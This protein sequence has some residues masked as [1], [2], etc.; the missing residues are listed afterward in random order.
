MAFIPFYDYTAN[1]FSFK[2]YIIN[3]IYWLYDIWAYYIQLIIEGIQVSI[4]M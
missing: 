4:C 1:K 3:I 2:L